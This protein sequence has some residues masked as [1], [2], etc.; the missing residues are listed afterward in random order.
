[1][2]LDLDTISA[3]VAAISALIAVVSVITVFYQTKKGWYVNI[4]APQRLQWAENLR[5]AVAAFISAFYK[6]S[7]LM[8]FRDRVFLYLNPKNE[9]HVPLIDAIN[10]TCSKRDGERSQ[11]DINRVIEATQKLLHWNWWVIKT[12][13]TISHRAEIKRDKRIQKRANWIEK[14]ERG[15]G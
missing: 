7:N 3:I 9:R 15:E 10:T 12:E 4:V 11:E 5:I 14:R 6:A 2:S 1:M 8:E 13:A